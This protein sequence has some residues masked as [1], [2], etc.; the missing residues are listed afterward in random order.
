MAA[1]AGSRLDLTGEILKIPIRKIPTGLQRYFP[2]RHGWGTHGF[3]IMPEFNGSQL[4]LN[5]PYKC[6]RLPVE[7]RNTLGAQRV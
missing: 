7:C 6:F 5:G 4:S 3:E 1:N 2:V